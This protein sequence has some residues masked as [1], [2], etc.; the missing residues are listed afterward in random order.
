MA[1]R[2]VTTHEH[3][4]T[5]LWPPCAAPLRDYVRA[6]SAARLPHAVREDGSAGCWQNTG[7]SQPWACEDFLVPRHFVGRDGATPGGAGIER[8]LEHARGLLCGAWAHSHGLAWHAVDMGQLRTLLGAEGGVLTPLTL[9][10][11]SIESER[12]IEDERRR[13]SAE[14]SRP[15]KMGDV[16]VCVCVCAYV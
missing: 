8:E 16:C 1:P 2:D 15:A 7:F 4:P 14:R 11:V 13:E 9:P 5:E 6:D 10:A 3:D 12:F